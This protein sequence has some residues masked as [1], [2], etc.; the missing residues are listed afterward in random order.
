MFIASFCN[1][2]NG[3]YTFVAKECSKEKCT[4][5]ICYLVLVHNNIDDTLETLDGIRKQRYAFIDIM[6]VD[7][8]SDIVNADLLREYAKL[9]HLTYIYR[10][11]NDGYA[12]GNNYGWNL[13]KDKYDYVFVVNNDIVFNDREI[14][15]KIMHIFEEDQN[16]AIIGPTIL[17]DDNKKI[18][19]TK[20]HKLFFYKLYTNHLYNKS[21][22][23][24]E[25]P[26][27]IGCFL[28]IRVKAIKASELFDNSF[29]MYGEELD[30]C[31]RVWN[32]GWKVVHMD[33]EIS[34]IYHKG[35]ASPFNERRTPCWKFYLCMRNSVLCARNF[36]AW[37]AFL[38]IILH[39]AAIFR[40]V[41]FS[42]YERRCRFSSL[43]GFF[44]GLY[45]IIFNKSSSII[46]AD[47]R[48]VLKK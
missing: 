47:A 48:R 35:G 12:G 20:L 25:R 28:A 9:H 17:Y 31:L 15:S 14:T 3:F 2:A 30:L 23:F 21:E 36:T 42:K 34:T 33:D 16:I 1:T 13:L 46:L 10:N 41:L 29:F 11:I 8:K 32:S 19:V 4:M 37:Y 6:I 7:N 27:V 5:T 39:F 44:R 26:A 40:I 18:D 43:K 22:N 45:F 38:F 24:T